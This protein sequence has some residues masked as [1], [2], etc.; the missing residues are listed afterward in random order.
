M[1]IFFVNNFSPQEQIGGSEIQCWLLAKYL[2]K[3]GHQTAYLALRGLAGQ[4]QEL[5]DGFKVYYLAGENDNK[6]KIFINFYRLL[7]K[8]KT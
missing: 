4:R 3:R 6:L 1:K 7:K 8:R 5:G 2:A